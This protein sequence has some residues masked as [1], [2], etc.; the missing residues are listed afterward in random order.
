M[1]IKFK[2]IALADDD[3]EDL[4]LLKDA[5]TK[6]CPNICFTLADNGATLLDK[7]NTSSTPDFIILDINMPYISGKECLKVIKTRQVMKDVP[8]MM[9]STSSNQC[10]IKECFSNGADFY[11][12]KPSSISE[13]E[14][15][16]KDICMG[17]IKSSV[18][19]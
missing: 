12:I 2:H 13:I 7:L 3:N 14:Q 16:G 5:I 9:Y 11:V 18:N 4:E 8:V 10:D 15:I 17:T 1:K 19:V 6:S